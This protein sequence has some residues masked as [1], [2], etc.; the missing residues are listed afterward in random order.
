M[1]ELYDQMSLS[2]S[3]NGSLT[4]ACLPESST[5]SIDPS[6]LF[7][8]ENAHVNNAVHRSQSEPASPNITRHRLRP[9]TMS[10]NAQSQEQPLPQ[11]A[12]NGTGTTYSSLQQRFQQSFSP[13]KPPPQTA[14]RPPY[15]PAHRNNSP[16][17]LRSHQYLHHSSIPQKRPLPPTS[18]PTTPPQS[19][20]PGPTQQQYQFLAHQDQTTLVIGLL[21]H[22][23]RLTKE[24][25]EMKAFIRLGYSD[26]DVAVGLRRQVE[27]S[28]LHLRNHNKLATELTELLKPLP[29][30]NGKIPNDVPQ[31]GLQIQALDHQTIGTLLDLY[32]LPFIPTMFLHEKK[33]LYLRFIGASRALM[34]RIL[35]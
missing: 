35:D 26:D 8:N 29:L 32:E 3:T 34:H 17:R 10:P 20:T 25:E 24:C 2:G 22:L 12:P 33:T 23:D 21:S 6:Q 31:T 19:L 9:F 11:I 14:P 30:S 16:S 5:S 7:I 28:R 27:G 18:A 4:Y 13:A 1:A 15:S